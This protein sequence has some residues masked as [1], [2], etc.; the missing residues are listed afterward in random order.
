MEKQ[1]LSMSSIVGIWKPR[2][3]AASSNELDCPLSF[4]ALTRMFRFAGALSL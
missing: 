2:D 1:D 3:Q 4:T